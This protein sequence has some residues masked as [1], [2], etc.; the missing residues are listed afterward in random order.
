MARYHGRTVSSEMINQSF[1][2]SA[3]AKLPDMLEQATSRLGLAAEFTTKSILDVPAFAFPL[4]AELNDG[5]VAVVTT[6]GRDAVV[7]LRTDVAERVE[8]E[9]PLEETLK[10][11]TGRM[12]ILSTVSSTRD[13]RLGSY[14]AAYSP[15]WFRRLLFAD[16]RRHVEIAVASFLANLLALASSLFAMQVW[17]RVV[18]AQSIP[19][20]WVLVSGVG[21]A[22]LFEY[23][24]RVTRSKLADHLGQRVDLSISSMVFGRV[25]NIRNDARPKS[26][27]ALIAQLRETETVRE[28]LASASLTAAVDIPFAITFLVVIWL[29]AGPVVWAVVLA[30][31]LIIIPGFLLQ[32]PLA[33]LSTAASRESALRHAILVESIVGIEDIK[34]LQ[35]E[36]RFHRL[37]DKYCHAS[38]NASV[39]QRHKVSSYVF[40]IQSVQQLTYVSVVVV[41]V[42]MIL[43]GDMTTGSVIGASILAG[44]ALSPFAQLAQIF[45]RWQSAKMARAGLD[46]LIKKPLDYHSDT[47]KLRRT[48]A[49]GEYELAD[50]EFSYNPESPP[51][52]RIENLHIKPGEKVALIGKNGA[53]KSTLLKLLANTFPPTAGTVSLDGADMQQIDVSDTRRHVS[54]LTQDS[55]L[56]FGSLIENIKLGAPLAT[57]DAVS[58]ALVLSGADEVVKSLPKGL[59]TEVS[60][61]GNGLSGGQRQSILLART[62]LRNAQ[63]LLLDEPTAALDDVSERQFLNSL[64]PWA[65]G[66]TVIISTHRPAV[67]G[68]VDRVI[69]LNK[70]RVVL[71]DTRD[72]ALR[73]L[74]M[75]R[76]LAEGNGPA[77]RQQERKQA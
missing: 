70:G 63:V 55:R 60:E 36:A 51:S 68:L 76:G 19:T 11:F 34:S 16:R 15:S 24:L 58:R 49:M 20:L 3:S 31:P 50:V 54:L 40:W 8:W 12:L 47:E 14:L 64:R 2:W 27:G 17:D 62:L 41:G 72:V 43:A 25:L 13:R 21:L 37:W 73:R 32:I 59:E 77:P 10:R 71:D 69:V 66:R 53:G 75:M 61:G 33:R 29:I 44:R 42:Y 18:P 56:F 46:E 6:I 39:K 38:S 28:V 30:L 7:F 67:L 4:I 1:A 65:A 52:L 35:A 57:H 48:S 45:T 74:G 5:T 9:S 23:I 26:T 22:V